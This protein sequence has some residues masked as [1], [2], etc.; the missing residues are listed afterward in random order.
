MRRARALFDYAQYLSRRSL[1]V[2]LWAIEDAVARGDIPGAL[3]HY[4][5]ALRTKRDASAL[6]FP[7]L[8]SAIVD[9]TVRNAVATTLARRPVWGQGFVN[10]VASNGTDPLAS[11]A[12]FDDL[13]RR[14]VAISNGANAIVIAA[15]LDTGRFDAAWSYYA[16]IRGGADRRKSRDPRFTATLDEPSPLDWLLS[17]AAGISTSIQRGSD[18]G[19]FDFAVGPSI[20]GVLLRQAQL[21][22]PGNYVL[23]GRSIGIDQP[24]D[25]LPY[26]VVSCRDGREL[27]RVIMPASASAGGRFA[28][29]FSVPDDCPMQVLSLIARPSSAVAG[30]V[31]Q[32]DRVTLR[33]VSQ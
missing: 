28:G 29:R 3:R 24:A 26:W 9:P 10:F 12:L 16:G 33:G 5:I 21:L 18:G 22:L 13:R 23:E 30:L 25:T 7:V 6:L 1:Q 32:I 15:L 8:T 11:A 27:G 20:G 4:D 14:D 31:G 19:I 17:D 2:Q